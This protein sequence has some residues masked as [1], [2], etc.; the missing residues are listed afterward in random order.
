MDGQV[1]HLLSTHPSDYPQT[2]GTML[3]HGQRS[4]YEIDYSASEGTEVVYRLV[5][6]GKSFPP[7]QEES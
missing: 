5:G 7:H 6:V 1:Q 4:W 2:M 3:R